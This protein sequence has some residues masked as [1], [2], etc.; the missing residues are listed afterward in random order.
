MIGFGDTGK[1]L[2]WFKSYLTGRWQRLK[3]G[4]CLPSKADLRFGV[5][6]GV[7]FGSSASHALYHSIEQHDL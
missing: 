5:P 4:D 6:K 3:I 1:A 7:R 2:N